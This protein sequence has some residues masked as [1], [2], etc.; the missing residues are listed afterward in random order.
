MPL[1]E[2]S[3]LAS[4]TTDIAAEIDGEHADLIEEF[5][6]VAAKFNGLLPRTKLEF[7]RACVGVLE[8][9]IAADVLE[10]VYEKAEAA[11][12][13][14]AAL[15]AFQ[16]LEV[17]TEHERPDFL[18]ACLAVAIGVEPRSQ[19]EIAAEFDVERATVSKWARKFVEMFGLVPGRGMRRPDAVEAYRRRAQATWE[20]RKAA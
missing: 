8:Q 13:R 1:R 15:A 18:R 9:A 14:V 3:L 7:T 17:L 6:A 2:D 20:D 4:Y 12:H 19:V 11:A 10:S 16:L 5:G